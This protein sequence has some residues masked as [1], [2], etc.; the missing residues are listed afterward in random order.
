MSIFF[1]WLFEMQAPS[2]SFSLEVYLGRFVVVFT[3]RAKKGLWLAHIFWSRL[4]Y[5][6]ERFTYRV[7]WPPLS[8]QQV[9]S[10]TTRK[11]SQSTRIAGGNSRASGQRCSYN[12]HYYRV[13][14]A[15]QFHASSDYPRRIIFEGGIS[16][17]LL[18]ETGYRP[19]LASITTNS[20]VCWEA[21]LE[22]PQC[23]T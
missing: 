3:N 2:T 16:I 18:L 5:F 22:D 4:G 20:I 10:R 11:Y 14:M 1:N 7:C 15:K 12:H 21:N 17:D 9:E 13:A 19:A 23:L 6:Q 8:S